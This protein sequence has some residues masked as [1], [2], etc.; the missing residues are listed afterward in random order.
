MFTEKDVG[1]RVNIQGDDVWIDGQRRI[2]SWQNAAHYDCSGKIRTVSERE[3]H[4]SGKSQSVSANMCKK[5]G[6]VRLEDGQEFDNPE[7]IVCSNLSTQDRKKAWPCCPLETATISER[8]CALSAINVVA[9]GTQSR[10]QDL[11][12][13]GAHNTELI[14]GWIT[15]K[16]MRAVCM[17]TYS[18]L[19]CEV[20]VLG[21]LWI[22]LSRSFVS[23]S[24]SGNM[25]I[26]CR[27]HNPL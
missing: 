22:S 21:S 12:K 5:K 11:G 17:P 19:M 27:C 1:K 8:H 4:C 25:R 9:S 16:N 2:V 13:R 18:C 23:G 10:N 7:A 15:I 20:H 6:K 24:W 3:C 14:A 26:W